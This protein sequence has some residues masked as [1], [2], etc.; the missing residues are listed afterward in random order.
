M[1][2]ETGDGGG[3]GVRT[4]R[5][6]RLEERMVEVRVGSERGSRQG[7]G[8]ARA[9]ARRRH[10]TPRRKKMEEMSMAKVMQRTGRGGSERQWRGR[11]WK[12]R[13]RRER[14][15]S[16]SCGEII[17]TMKYYNNKNN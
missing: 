8:K 4:S 11:A 3:G 16:F 15:G 17:N 7:Q 2:L 14:Q 1:S 10:S 5:E 6:V 13:Q 9:R 12:Q